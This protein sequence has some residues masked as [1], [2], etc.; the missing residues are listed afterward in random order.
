MQMRLE[1]LLLLFKFGLVFGQALHDRYGQ[2][3]DVES[4]QKP[5]LSNTLYEGF[6]QPIF[7]M[8]DAQDP[9]KRDQ[10]MRDAEKSLE[11]YSRYPSIYPNRPI[12]TTEPPSLMDTI[13]KPFEPLMNP[14]KEQL[15]RVTKDQSFFTNLLDGKPTFT[16][17]NSESPRKSPSR[18]SE[19]SKTQLSNIN[20]IQPPQAP[21]LSFQLSSPSSW[22]NIFHNTWPNSNLLQY[23]AQA[24]VPNQAQYGTQN[25]VLD[26]QRYGTQKAASDQYRYITQNPVPN[27]PQHTPSTPSPPALPI[28]QISQFPTPLA[29]LLEPLGLNAKPRQDLQIGRDK[30]VSILGMPVGRRDGIQLNPLQGLSLGGQNMY[31]PI[32]VNDKYNVNWNFLDGLGKLFGGEI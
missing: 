17:L 4:P 5:P 32:A 23:N 27:Q 6:I 7:N 14:F 11:K 13:F 15:D 20:A 19:S 1:I 22:P 9:K 29:S 25:S 18:S 8:I 21:V 10:V 12:V 3:A 28:Q 26:Q 30:S 16:P 24:S 2:K 31:G